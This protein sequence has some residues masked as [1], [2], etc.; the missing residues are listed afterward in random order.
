MLSKKQKTIAFTG[1]Y[2]FVVLMNAIGVLLQNE[3][4]LFVFRPLIFGSLMLLYFF[5]VK[6]VNILFLLCQFLGL[7]GDFLMLFKEDFFVYAVLLYIISQILLSSIIIKFK[8]VKLASTIFYFAFAFFCFIVVYLFVL[9]YLRSYTVLLMAFGVSISLLT[10]LSFVNYLNKMYMA[11][12]LLFLG[13]AIGAISVVLMSL[14]IFGS[15]NF[16]TNLPIFTMNAIMHYLICRSFIIREDK[17]PN[18]KVLQS[19]IGF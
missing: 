13:L 11:N 7:T 9:E 14:D 2:L 4:I 17:T 18:K 5:S 8:H 10:A 15:S 16:S 1:L 3:I 12:Y 19:I 6:K